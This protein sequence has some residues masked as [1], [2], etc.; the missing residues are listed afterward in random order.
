MFLMKSNLKLRFLKALSNVF[1][2]TN[3]KGCEY[4]VIVFLGMANA[5]QSCV[6]KIWRDMGETW[7]YMPDSTKIWRK[8]AAWRPPE[9][10]SKTWSFQN[11]SEYLETMKVFTYLNYPI[12]HQ[13]IWTFL[14]FLDIF[15]RN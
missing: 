3:I 11:K 14:L 10:A 12:I 4:N 1:S 5:C 13:S 8:V 15:Q 6:S 2:L 9:T 7:R